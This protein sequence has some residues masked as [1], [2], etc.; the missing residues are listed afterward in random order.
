MSHP[1]PIREIPD[2]LTPP[3]AWKQEEPETSRPARAEPAVPAG[4]MD[5]HSGSKGPV[6]ASRHRRNAV[7]Y[8]VLCLLAILPI[9]LQMSPGWQ[10][11]GLGLF[12]PGAGFL[13]VGGWAVLL[14][15]LT[16]GLF[17]LSVVAWFW[18]GM[19]VAPLTVW[20]GS[21]V[22]AGAMVGHAIWG[23]AAFL[24]PLFAAATFGVF[25][26]RAIRK[27]A[28]DQERLEMRKGFFATSLAEVGERVAS[29]AVERER[30][31]TPDQLAALRY[32]L[33]RALQ[34]VGQYQGY[35]VLDQFQP[36]ALRYQINHMGFG[37]GGGRG[38]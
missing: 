24:A 3:F 6:T 10:A 4:E 29:S 11:F 22:L 31:L 19:V 21:A 30:E 27:R 35:D 18:A 17:W 15:P 33:D 34:P 9:L 14:F 20:L 37:G 2:S 28:A 26:Y 8:G 13:A 36:A 38:G 5:L 25:Q 16:V 7:V 12:M 32:V 23:P 1:S